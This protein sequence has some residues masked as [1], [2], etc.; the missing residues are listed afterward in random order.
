MKGQTK[1]ARQ[2]RVV[3]W[4]NLPLLEKTEATREIKGLLRFTLQH[5]S[6][7]IKVAI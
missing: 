6:P 4:V 1:R 3:A 5:W 7:C 2:M